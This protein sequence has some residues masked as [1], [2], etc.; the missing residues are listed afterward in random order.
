MN[1]KPLTPFIAL[2]SDISVTQ[3]EVNKRIKRIERAEELGI[4]LTS[5]DTNTS[6]AYEEY[7][8]PYEIE[9]LSFIMRD[10]EIPEELKHKF[11]KFEEKHCR[12]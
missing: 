7:T 6:N 1:N 3:E 10:Q 11:K 9:A 4:D 12:K 5:V 2:G 8:N